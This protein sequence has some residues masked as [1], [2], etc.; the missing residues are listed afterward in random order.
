MGGLHAIVAAM[1]KSNFDA[2]VRAVEQGADVNTTDARQRTPLMVFAVDDG[3]T[4]TLF[5]ARCEDRVR[6]L[7]DAGA[8]PNRHGDMELTA[9]HV[10]ARRGTPTV[11]RLLIDRGADVNARDFAGETPLFAAAEDNPEMIP[12]LLDAGTEVT[13]EDSCGQT[14]L[15]V[16]RDPDV[17]ATLEAAG[18]IPGRAAPVFEFG[19]RR[20]SRRSRVPARLKEFLAGPARSIAQPAPFDLAGVR[21]G[22]RFLKRPSIQRFEANDLDPEAFPALHVLGTLG[23]LGAGAG[24]LV[25]DVSDA[26]FPVL[27]WDPEVDVFQRVADSLDAFV[28]RVRGA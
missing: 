27:A 7:L 17:R 12:V 26:A 11:A 24:F 6:W 8:D 13:V 5:D 2:V 9:L 4:A 10:V 21:V 28:A 3:S 25:I 23:T 19:R 14:A 18:A 1:A 15:D 20:R 16:A 22:V